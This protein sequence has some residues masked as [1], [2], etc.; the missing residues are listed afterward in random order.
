MA[1]AK[2]VPRVH[3]RDIQRIDREGSRH[4]SIESGPDGM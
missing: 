3:G 1:E 2:D 4:H